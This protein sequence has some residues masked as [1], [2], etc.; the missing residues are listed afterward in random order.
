MDNQQE[1]FEIR[2]AWLAAIIEGEGWVTL[3]KRRVFQK[4]KKHTIAYTPNIGMTNSDKEIVNETRS[5]FHLLGLKYRFQTRNGKIGSDGI[6]R[7]TRYEISIA[8]S[9]DIKILS[10]N[11]L[12]YMI[13]E[14]KN[15]IHKLIEFFKI[16]SNKGIKGPLSKYGYEEESIYKELYCFKGK[17]RSKILND[18][19][20]CPLVSQG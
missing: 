17:S 14:K 9:R 7:K 6:L 15:R 10:Q 11:I 16:R 8:S 13:G 3:I 1:R 19:T 2:M 18:F 20:P 4:N 12:P 5:L